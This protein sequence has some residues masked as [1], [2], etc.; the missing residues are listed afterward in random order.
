MASLA[1]IFMECIIGAIERQLLHVV[2]NRADI[3]HFIPCIK[4]E[5]NTMAQKV[6]TLLEDDLHGGEADETVTFALDGTTYEIDLTKKNAAE[7]RKAMAVYVGHARKVSGSRG[8]RRSRGS[9]DAKTIREWAQGQGLDVPSRGRIP[10]EVRKQ[11][12]AAH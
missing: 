9:S 6:I 7:L 2:Y 5:G 12:E 4:S 3:N 1:D 10:Q 8:A 11:Y